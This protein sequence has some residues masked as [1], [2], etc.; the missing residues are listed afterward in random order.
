MDTSR[1]KILKEART[2][3]IWNVIYDIIEVV[4]S[5]I[6][7]FTANS[8]ALIGWGLDST[9][10]VISAGTL[11]WRLHGEIKGLDERRVE[12]RKM[13][14]LYVIAI[15][16]TLICIFI[17]YDS[18]SKL[19]SRE[20]ASWST[21]GIAILVVSLAVNPILIYYKRKYGNKLDSPAL[22]ADA[23]DTFICLY[24]TVVVLIGLLLVKWLG[25]WW[26][27]PVAALLIVPYAA[28]EGL[29]AF[30]K[31]QGIRNDIDKE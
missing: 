10:E 14:T 17:T 31:A 27:D 20:T 4:V 23:K 26:A 1:E 28:K 30:S 15:S 12:R 24:Q 3:Q 25:W 7:G 6:A 16:F 8:S 2:L 13:T 22:L 19:T 21:V 29:E 11:G 5:L 9:I 18:I